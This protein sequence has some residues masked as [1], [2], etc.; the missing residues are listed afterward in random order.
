MIV[1][2]CQAIGQFDF[3]H[4][5]TCAI[6]LLY[7]TRFGGNLTLRRRGCTLKRMARQTLYV[8][9]SRISD[10]VLM[11]IVAGDTT[12]ARISSAEAFAVGQPVWLE[13]HA[14][15]TTPRA[16][17]DRLPSAMALPAEIR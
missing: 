6:V 3:G 5:A 15:F 14:E 16:P 2:D 10:Q 1:E 11:G 13:A 4:V 17:N 9:S 8:V 7:W 12:D